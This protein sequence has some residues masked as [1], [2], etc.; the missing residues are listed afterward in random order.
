MKD[1]FTCSYR[2]RAN[3]V[4]AEFIQAG[5]GVLNNEMITK[6][7]ELFSKNIETIQYFKNWKIWLWLLVCLYKLTD[8][9]KLKLAIL[10][11]YNPIILKMGVIANNTRVQDQIK[12]YFTRSNFQ[13]LAGILSD[14]N[15]SF[16]ADQDQ[17]IMSA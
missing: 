9:H 10:E 1:Q 7:L 17:G 6:V 13:P 4:F 12:A 3:K 8:D 2:T 5:Q 14:F 16:L 15:N 11:R